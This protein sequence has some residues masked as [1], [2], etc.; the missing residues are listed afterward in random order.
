MSVTINAVT[1]PANVVAK[2]GD[3]LAFRVEVGADCAGLD[4]SQ[5]NYIAEVW[6]ATRR[7]DENNPDGGLVHVAKIHD[8]GVEVDVDALV[9]TMEASKTEAFTPDTEYYWF[10]KWMLDPESQKTLS[11]GSFKVV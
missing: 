9:L 7:I 6:S 5:Y 10:V 3:Y 11:H 2:R 8:L 1:C 4:L